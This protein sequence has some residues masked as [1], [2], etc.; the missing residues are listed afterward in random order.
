MF[1]EYREIKQLVGDK[2]CKDES[3]KKSLNVVV[4]MV[5]HQVDGGAFKYGESRL[6]SG[7]LIP[8]WK[9]G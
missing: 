5:L 8:K 9:K 2:R 1:G 7:Y 3:Q 6:T 4:F